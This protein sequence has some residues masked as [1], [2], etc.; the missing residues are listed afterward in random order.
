M[1]IS[2]AIGA[3][4]RGIR[5]WVKKYW[6]TCITP[7]AKENSPAGMTMAMAKAMAKMPSPFRGDVVRTL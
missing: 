6:M 4:A 7:A 1:V 2:T 3:T 5:S